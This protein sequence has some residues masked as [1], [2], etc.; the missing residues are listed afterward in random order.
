MFQQQLIIVPEPT[1]FQE[2]FAHVIAC[3]T[4]GFTLSMLRQSSESRHSST[5]V[6]KRTRHFALKLAIM[7]PSR[8]CTSLVV[9]GKLK[10]TFVF[11]ILNQP[12]LK[13][14]TSHE[15]AVHPSGIRWVELL[16]S[17]NHAGRSVPRSRRCCRSRHCCRI[18][19]F[20]T[21]ATCK[22][23]LSMVFHSASILLLLIQEHPDIC[24]KD[25]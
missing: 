21:S 23:L 16:S 1:S 4:S 15:H 11:S 14:S 7:P 10:T 6:T 17:N 25:F 9:L 8:A 20:P 5:H 18:F 3:R 24:S 13:L 12:S 22:E 19:S 2:S